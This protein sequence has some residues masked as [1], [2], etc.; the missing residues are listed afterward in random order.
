MSKWHEVTVT[1]T[2]LVKTSDIQGTINLHEF[3]TFPDLDPDTEVRFQYGKADWKEV[4]VCNC[5]ENCGC[6]TQV[7]DDGQDCD[8]CLFI[9]YPPQL[10]TNYSYTRKD[11]ND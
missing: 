10:F 8:E 7:N 4:F 3:S 6:D 5:G 11:N 2:F 1:Q 9:H